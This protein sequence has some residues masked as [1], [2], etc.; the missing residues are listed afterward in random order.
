[1]SRSCSSCCCRR[2]VGRHDSRGSASNAPARTGPVAIG[3]RAAARR[4]LARTRARRTGSAPISTVYSQGG[5]SPVSSGDCET[6][7]QLARAGRKLVHD[8]G[9]EN[10]GVRFILG[11]RSAAVGEPHDFAQSGERTGQDGER[12]DDFEQREAAFRQTVS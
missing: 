8:R 3:L 7:V 12:E 5:S 1:M 4:E 10:L 11:G 2:R 9:G 6:A